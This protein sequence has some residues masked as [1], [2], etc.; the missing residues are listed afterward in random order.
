MAKETNKPTAKKYVFIR[1]AD[2]QSSAGQSVGNTHFNNA[3]VE[4]Y[5]EGLL[6][7][8]ALIGLKNRVFEY[9]KESDYEVWIEKQKQQ[10]EFF[11]LVQEQRA[12]KK[13]STVSYLKDTTIE[14][15]KKAIEAEEEEV[16]DEEEKAMKELAKKKPV[17]TKTTKTGD[18]EVKPEGG[19]K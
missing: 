14:D 13:K 4:C 16:E 19:E 6:P 17:V 5:E 10:G 15:T 18:T 11:K 7:Q 9:C 12:A 2:R 3:T 8:Q 1:L